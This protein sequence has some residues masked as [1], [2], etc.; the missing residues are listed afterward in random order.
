MK[1]FLE[2]QEFKNYHWNLKIIK[3][4]RSHPPV[5]GHFATFSGFARK[6]YIVLQP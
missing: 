4:F 3:I 2:A 6:F 5:S 1:W